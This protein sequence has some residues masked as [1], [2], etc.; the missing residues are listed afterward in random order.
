MTT[1]ETSSSRPATLVEYVSSEIYMTVVPSILGRLRRRIEDFGDCSYYAH[2]DPTWGDKDS[3]AKL[4]FFKGSEYY[5]PKCG[6]LAIKYSD[7]VLL[8]ERIEYILL[9]TPEGMSKSLNKSF[10]EEAGVRGSRGMELGTMRIFSDELI[11][12]W[13]GKNWRKI[14]L[15]E[16][17]RP[18]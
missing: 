13:N 15:E 5:L 14:T 12:F 17:K 4:P 2:H 1:S 11:C 9:S 16:A 6:S 18:C 3:L 8:L 10:G 7:I